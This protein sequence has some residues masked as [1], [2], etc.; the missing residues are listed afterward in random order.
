MVSAFLFSNFPGLLLGLMGPGAL[1]AIGW[2]VEKDYVGK[3]VTFA[4][5]IAINL[6]FVNTGFGIGN[7][8]S[9]QNWAIVAY[10]DLGLIM[11]VLG[12]LS[13]V[14]KIK[15]PPVFDSVAMIYSTVP[16]GIM[17]LISLIV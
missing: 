16:A 10:L 5:A 4:N 12:L 17:I 3:F 15:L 1:V 11:G 6:A 2:L 9:F 14:E 13:Y 8:A 7:N